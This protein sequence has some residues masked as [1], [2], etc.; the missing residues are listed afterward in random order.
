MKVWLVYAD[1]HDY[2][3]MSQWLVGIYDSE[4]KAINASDKERRR[5]WEG[6]PDSKERGLP[7]IDVTEVEVE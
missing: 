7:N 6:N 2:D 3:A 1:D 4:P 5:Y